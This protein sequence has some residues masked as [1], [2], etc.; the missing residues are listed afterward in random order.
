MPSQRV[1]FFSRFGLKSLERYRFCTLWSEIGQGFFKKEPAGRLNN[2]SL[3]S[4]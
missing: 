2:G 3:G 1:W 4:E